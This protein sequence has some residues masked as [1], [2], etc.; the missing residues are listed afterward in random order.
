MGLKNLKNGPRRRCK[1]VHVGGGG[2]QKSPKNGPH[3]LR[4]PPHLVPNC[5]YLE[6]FP[7][8]IVFKEHFQM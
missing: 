8:E 3:G 5:V 1:L 7:K 6:H 4:M 2:G